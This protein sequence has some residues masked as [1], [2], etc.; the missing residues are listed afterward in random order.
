MSITSVQYDYLER[1][2]LLDTYL[3]SKVIASSAMQVRVVIEDSKVTGQ[4]AEFINLTATAYGMQGNLK[5]EGSGDDYYQGQQAR[6]I[7][8]DSEILGQQANFKIEGSEDDY[9]QGQQAEINI[10]DAPYYLGQQTNLKIVGTGDDYYQGQQ[11]K[12][13][14]QG[15]GD[16][17][18]QGQQTKFVVKTIP[19]TGMELKLDNFAHLQVPTY[20]LD[21]YLTKAYLAEKTNAHGG[22]Q[23]TFVVEDLNT[24]GQQVNLKIVSPDDDNFG[25]QQAEFRIF[26]DL[27]LGMQVN[28]ERLFAIGMQANVSL[29]NTTNLRILCEFPSRGFEGASGTNAWG[30]TAGVGEN[31]RAN[32][33]AAGDF[34]VFN[35]N[36]D[37]VEQVWRSNGATTGINLECDTERAQGVFLDTLAILNHNLTSSASITLVGSNVSDFSTIGVSISLAA[38]ADDVNLYYISP[39]LPKA[40]YRYWRISI[41]DAT[42]TSGYL[43][44]GTIVFGASQIFVGECFVDDI[45]FELKDFTDSVA[46]EGFTNVKN[47]RAQKKVL[48]L[49]FRSLDFTRSNFKLMRG[50]FQTSRTVLKCLYIPTPDIN[51]DDY[52]ARFAVFAKMK[53]VPVERHNNKGSRAD[54][55]SFTLE[56]DE[57]E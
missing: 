7:V 26:D 55:V 38:K 43:Q 36:T 25:G 19:A 46:T 48:R 4:Q 18:Y 15:S 27:A 11:A 5:I 54:Y 52:T 24:Q 42:N 50:L 45:D 40:G 1:P 12:I 34:G 37:I 44:I 53:A 30:N 33:T 17:Y 6:F 21:P 14:I 3:E 10:V 32:S 51:D 31:W 39:E 2:Y 28:V 9:Y 29:Y 35:L 57:S 20:L 16:D 47:S 8:K 49:D 23:A 22:M 56:L 13:E 41:D